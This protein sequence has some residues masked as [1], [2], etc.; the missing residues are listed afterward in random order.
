VRQTNA[1]FTGKLT[2]RLLNDD[3][4]TEAEFSV[5]ASWVEAQVNAVSVPFIDTPYG[6]GEPALEFEYPDT[7]KALPVY[8]RGENEAAFFA[9]WDER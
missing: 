1:A 9:R 4:K 3:S 7:A 5:G 8:R 2:L 6:Q